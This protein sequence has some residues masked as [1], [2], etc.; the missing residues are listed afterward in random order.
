MIK[1]HFVLLNRWDEARAGKDLHVIDGLTVT[2]MANDGG[3]YATVLG[4]ICLAS[5]QHS[6]NI[7]INHVEDSNLFIGMCKAVVSTAYV[8]PHAFG[9]MCCV[10]ST[11]MLMKT[12][13]NWLQVWLWVV[14]TSTLIPRR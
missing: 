7:Y 3:D 6:W 2:K 11:L 8:H 1:T 5:G 13:H 10:S 12:P 4:T 9:V 14:M